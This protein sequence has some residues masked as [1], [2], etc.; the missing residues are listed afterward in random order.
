[1]SRT[2]SRNLGVT[3]LKRRRR[4]ADPMRELDGLPQELR[5]WLAGAALP[6]SPRSAQRAFN[7]ALA[8]TEDPQQA[9]AELDQLQQRKIRRD[10]RK[11]WGSHYPEA[12]TATDIWSGRRS[13]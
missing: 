10:S 5:G 1:M 4:S 6:W 9:L 12:A 13:S 3:K 8:R 11:V 2:A 7:K